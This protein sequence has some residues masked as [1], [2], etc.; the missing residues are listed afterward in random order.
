M[1]H[2]RAEEKLDVE[3]KEEDLPIGSPDI[4]LYK[5]LYMHGRNKFDV[6]ADQV[7]HLRANLKTGG[8]L[9]ADACCGKP[10]FDRAFRTFAKQLF[11][12]A[13]LEPIPPDDPLYGAEVNRTAITTV[14]LRRERPDGQG[15]EAEF[16]DSRPTY[17]EGIKVGGRWVVI[18]SRYDIGCAL[19][20]HA[21]SDCRGY[22]HESALK[23]G[24][25]AVM[26]ALKK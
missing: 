17:L 12:D 15:A 10:E 26:Y 1:R 7:D 23:I 20:K 9:L 16:R 2:V 8:L 22:D 3:L 18:Y 6:P 14:R 5:F 4:Y 25:A 11:P 21:S 13:N 19:E 24:T